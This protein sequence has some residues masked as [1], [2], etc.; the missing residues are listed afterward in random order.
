LAEFGITHLDMPL[1]PSAVWRAIQDS[2]E[3]MARGG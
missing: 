1:V 3:L 2:R